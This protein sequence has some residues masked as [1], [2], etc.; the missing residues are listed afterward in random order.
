M[1]RDAAD[2]VSIVMR[3]EDLRFPCYRFPP[4]DTAGAPAAA[5]ASSFEA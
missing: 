2:R 5:G 4:F 1:N 3:S